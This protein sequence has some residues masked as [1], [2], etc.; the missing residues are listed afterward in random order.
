[1]NTFSLLKGGACALAFSA[2]CSAQVLMLDFGPA[3]STGTDRLNSP[4]HTAAPSFTNTTWNTI[5][6]SDVTSGL[7]WSDGTAA[8][9]VSLDLGA[10]TSDA[11]RTISLSS[12]PSNG[13]GLTGSARNSGIYAGTAPGRDGIF[14]GGSS[15]NIRAVGLQVGGLSPGTYDIYI[16]GRNTNTASGHTQNFYAGKSAVGGNFDFSN[17]AVF[18]NTTVTYF[19]DPTEQNNAWSENSLANYARFT[20]TLSDGEFLQLA[21]FGGAGDGRGFLNSIQIVAVPEPSSSVV[22]AGLLSL[23]G[24][25]FLRRRT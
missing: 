2:V 11:S 14:N 22:I 18:A 5:G 7:L 23:A 25:V 15:S 16:T 4:Y 6:I 19:A 3:A 17:T 24:T 9:G 12:A 20:V 10:T 21:A 13:T 8:T 1:M